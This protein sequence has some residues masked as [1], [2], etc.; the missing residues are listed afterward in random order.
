MQVTEEQTESTAWEERKKQLGTITKSLNGLYFREQVIK[1]SAKGHN[2]L[3]ITGEEWD[4]KPWELACENG[5]VNLK[6]G[7]LRPGKP[8]DYIKSHSPTPYDPTAECPKFKK[9]LS[10]VLQD[11]QELVLFVK[12]ILGAGLIGESTYKQYIVILYGDRGRNGKDTLQ[13][14]ISHVLGRQLSGAIQSEILLDGGRF[15]RRSSQGPSADIMRLRGLR[16]AWAKETSEGRRFDSGM[17]KMLTGG[18]TLTGRMPYGKRDVEFEQSHLIILHTNSRPHV[19][20]DD[21][22]F[23][24]RV[25]TV[26]FELSFVDDPKED[27][28]R[29]KIEGLADQIKPEAAGILRWLVEGCLDYQKNG[30]PEPPAVAKANE[31]YIKDED[32]LGHFLEEKCIE[33]EGF[34][35]TSKD[36][37]S[38][39]TMWADDNNHRPLSGTNFGRQIGKRFNKKQI[40]AGRLAGYSGLKVRS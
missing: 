30:L 35:V 23:W 37:Y 17:A 7:V 21:A 26:P 34:E 36:L 39:Y 8:E 32:L 18:G 4:C 11:D 10:E 5:I 22:A 40:G 1:F 13:S 29:Q 24:K 16:L 33:G 20:A 19:Q 15:S 38:Q 3:G 25:K 12:R 31:D 27:H 2:S 14:I 6:T 9:F 28:E